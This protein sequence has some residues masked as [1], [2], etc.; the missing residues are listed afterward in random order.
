V[1]C[2]PATDSRKCIVT[3]VW[4]FGDGATYT[5]TSPTTNHTYGAATSYIMSLIVTD[6][7]NE[8]SMV[9]HVIQVTNTPPATTQQAVQ[10]LGATVNSL[11]GAGGLTPSTASMLTTKLN[12]AVQALDRGTTTAAKGQIGAFINQ[13]NAF[14]DSRRL[15]AA[16]AQ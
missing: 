4:S 15:T 1:G 13:V 3:Y 6:N 7:D 11:I 16:Q 10:Q 8:A 14:R 2:N 5:T 9:H 12:A